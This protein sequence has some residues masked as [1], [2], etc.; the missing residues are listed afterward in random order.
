ME[1]AREMQ[2]DIRHWYDLRVT[3]TSRATLHAETGSEARLAKTHERLLANEVHGIAQSDGRR[4]FALAGRRWRHSRNENQLAVLVLGDCL[5]EVR[6]DFRLVMTIG[7]QVVRRNTEIFGNFLDGLQCCRLGN[8][9]IASYSHFVSFIVFVLR[10]TR[11]VIA[12]GLSG[13]VLDLV[14][15]A[16]AEVQDIQLTAGVLRKTDN[17]QTCIQQFLC[18]H[19]GRTIFSHRKKFAR[20]EIPKDIPADKVGDAGTPIDVT[21]SH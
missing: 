12:V 11:N 19:T 16:Y 7:N 14:D 8:L 6:T 17:G 5:D 4:R 13:G 9:N 15:C 3:A 2:V 18:N 20:N 21:S 1:I 10:V